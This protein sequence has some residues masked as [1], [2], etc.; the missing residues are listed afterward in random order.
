MSA[1]QDSD[2]QSP[3]TLDRIQ[4]TQLPN[5]KESRYKG[6]SFD[7]VDC[8]D[9]PTHWPA[10]VAPR[11]GGTA[12]GLV[13]SGLAGGAVEAVRPSRGPAGQPAN[14]RLAPGCGPWTRSRGQR[15][16]SSQSACPSLSVRA[17]VPCVIGVE[18]GAR[19]RRSEYLLTNRQAAARARSWR[20]S[21]RRGYYCPAAGPLALRHFG[22][23]QHR[24]SRCETLTT[25][26]PRPRSGK[27]RASR[28]RL[29]GVPRAQREYGTSFTQRKQVDPYEGCFAVALVKGPRGL[30]CF[31]GQ[32]S[33]PGVMNL[34]ARMS[35][36]Q[37]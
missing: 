36:N 19:W 24:P 13:R 3:C 34:L 35:A 15:A 28:T 37:S 17:F 14:P 11:G 6:P 8:L 23:G 16:R 7:G 33:Q 29:R 1:H 27:R 20:R 26:T 32:P 31:R 10:P 5:R 25:P 18:A 9:V 2:E 4:T 21:Q 30:T 12:Q 22:W